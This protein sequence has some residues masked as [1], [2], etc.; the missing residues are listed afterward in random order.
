M[1]RNR[2]LQEEKLL[3]SLVTILVSKNTTAEKQLITAS[4][5]IH[6]LAFCVV[7]AFLLMFLCHRG[8]YPHVKPRKASRRL[9]PQTTD[10]SS[11]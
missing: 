2:G 4:G 7:F 10:S 5:V 1:A 3:R 11:C 8:G 9:G 6:N